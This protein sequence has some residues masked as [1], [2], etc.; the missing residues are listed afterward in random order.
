MN[1]PNVIRTML[2]KTGKRRFL[3]KIPP[4]NPR[5]DVSAQ[6]FW[7][8]EKKKGLGN[9]YSYV[10]RTPQLPGHILLANDKKGY[11]AIA[12]KGFEQALN[13]NMGFLLRWAEMY[14]AKDCR[15]IFYRMNI[16]KEKFGV[17]VMPVSKQEIQELKDDGGFVYYLGEKED[18]ADRNIAEFKKVKGDQTATEKLMRKGDILTIVAQLRR[19]VRSEGH[20]C[21]WP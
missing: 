11:G 14:K 12:P 10:C 3:M 8:G 16:K 4:N 6:I 19:I 15:P 17:H 21:E 13:L 2:A 5:Q 1:A 18:M 20:K 7:V 9:W